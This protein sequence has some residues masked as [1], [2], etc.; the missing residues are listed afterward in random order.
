M[1][2]RHITS[3]EK[4][5]GSCLTSWRV[6]VG[7]GSCARGPLTPPQSQDEGDLQ[8]QC[9]VPESTRPHSPCSGANQCR[10]QEGCWRVCDENRKGLLVPRL[11]DE[12]KFDL[13]NRSRQAIH[14]EGNVGVSPRP[15]ED[16]RNMMGVELGLRHLF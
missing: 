8:E 14:L 2:S 15:V 10:N 16:Y 5:A 9:P 7:P 12:H 1:G 11:Q 6:S 3:G 13:S 4:Q